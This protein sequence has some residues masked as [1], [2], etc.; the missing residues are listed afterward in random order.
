M[1]YNYEI[2]YIT[3]KIYSDELIHVFTEGEDSGSYSNTEN[4]YFYQYLRTTFISEKLFNAI[5]S[6]LNRDI[7]K[8][9]D[10]FYIINFETIAEDYNKIKNSNSLETIKNEIS[11]K[12]TMEE[13]KDYILSLSLEDDEPGF[14]WE[15]K[16]IYETCITNKSDYILVG[17]TP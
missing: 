5:N 13:L 12:N 3:G 1:G 2:F 9:H 17:L 10:Y 8:D 14:W 15:L 7:K 4:R 16:Q 11:L 6:H